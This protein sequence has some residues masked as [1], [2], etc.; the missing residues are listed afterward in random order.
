[1]TQGHYARLVAK[2][3][4]DPAFK[5]RLLSDPKAAMAAVGIT[6]P[7]GVGIRVV[8]DTPNVAHLVIPIQ[9]AGIRLA[10]VDLSKLTWAYESNSGPSGG[11]RMP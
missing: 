7:D 3:W 10:D 6:V 5:T 2:A 1:M 11:S 9:P 8:E 4:S